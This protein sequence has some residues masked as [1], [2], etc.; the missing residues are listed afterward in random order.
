MQRFIN[1]FCSLLFVIGIFFTCTISKAQSIYSNIDFEHGDMAGWT[2]GTGTCCPIQIS[3][4]GH[5]GNRFTVMSGTGTDP[6][7]NG[8]VPVVAPNGGN[9]SFRLGNDSA[10]GEAERVSYTFI[11]QPNAALVVYRYAVIFQYPPGH[12]AIRQPRFEVTVKNQSGTI[13]E[14][15]FYSVVCDNDIPGFQINGDIRFKNWTEAGIDLT[16]FIGQQITL[17]FATG[18]CGMG[19]HFGYAYIDCYATDLAIT[20]GDCN[21]DGTLTFTAPPGFNYLW[22]NNITTQQSNYYI[23]PGLL[24]AVELSSGQGCVKVLPAEIPDIFPVVDFSS[25]QHCKREALFQN[26]VSGASPVVNWYWNFGDN[27]TSTEE[28]PQHIYFTDG[29]Y[30]VFL[31][32][33]AANHCKA[34]ITKYITI[35]NNLIAGFSSVSEI[36][37]GKN[38]SFD[39]N[40]VAFNQTIIK[41]NW[42]FGDGNYSQEKNP[43][44][45][46]LSS[47]KMPVELIITTN[48][49]CEDRI[50]KQIEIINN[51][52]CQENALSTMYIPNCF[53]PNNDALNDEFRIYFQNMYDIDLA[54]YNRWGQCVYHGNGYQPGWD[55]KYHTEQ[56]QE[57]LYSYTLTARDALSNRHFRK[58]NIVLLR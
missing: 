22:T 55:G 40:S 17:E 9:F 7:T 16:D 37:K 6:Y 48:K 45:I 1:Q 50:I 32:V 4:S 14:C 31:E 23:E 57:D 34:H 35:N 2:A 42:D 29:N 12:P 27:L 53:S 10:G 18:D 52:E 38:I 43:E 33:G 13:P 56:A 36:C 51:E 58:G 54:I 11:V 20:S 30:P 28:N 8:I 39:D 21:P 47:G 25:E 24:V 5:L 41:W 49:N 3:G 15:G 44:H 46:Y 19:G 26:Q